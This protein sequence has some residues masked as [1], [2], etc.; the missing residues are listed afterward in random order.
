MLKK[1]IYLQLD[2]NERAKAL[3]SA[4]ERNDKIE[5]KKLISTREL[6][7][8]SNIDAEFKNKV[9]LQLIEHEKIDLIE[10]LVRSEDL[11]HGNN[12]QSISV[13]F[14]HERHAFWPP[15]DI[16]EDHKVSDKFFDPYSAKSLK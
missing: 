9:L 4:L 15:T 7:V 6:K 5:V 16:N 2:D 13:K 11:S 12:E 3:I 10:Q 1:T 14:I 8:S